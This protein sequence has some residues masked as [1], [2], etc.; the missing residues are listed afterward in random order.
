MKINNLSDYSNPLYK[1][2]NIVNLIDHELY[3]LYDYK[4]FVFKICDVSISKIDNVDVVITLCCTPVS[5]NL[6]YTYHDD[7][8]FEIDNKDI[9]FNVKAA[10]KAKYN[11]LRN[12]QLSFEL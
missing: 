4:V 7:M 8:E 11:K 3:W 10:E 1:T 12:R 5:K 9:Y 2:L 6:L